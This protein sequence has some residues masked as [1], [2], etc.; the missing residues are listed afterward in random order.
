[1]IYAPT[2]EFIESIK[3]DLRAIHQFYNINR[4]TV[5]FYT[6]SEPEKL[7]FFS[8]SR[9]TAFHKDFPFNNFGDLSAYIQAGCNNAFIEYNNRILFAVPFSN[10]I[11]DITDIKPI[12]HTVWDFGKYSFK[13]ENFDQSRG[14]MYHISYYKNLKNE[15]FSLLFYYETEKFILSRYAFNGTFYTLIFNKSD[16]KYDIVWQYIE[17]VYGVDVHTNIENGVFFRIINLEPKSIASYDKVLS[18]SQRELLKKISPEDNPGIIR[19]KL[20][21]YGQE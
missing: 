4:D 3:I 17:G 9:Q 10:I 8:R 6:S 2:L 13:P 19:Y 14:I 15:V 21:D 1:M 7:S 16:G 12:E 5:V 11:Y 20:K 18:D